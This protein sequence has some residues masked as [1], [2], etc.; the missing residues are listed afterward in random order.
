MVMKTFP[1][2]SNGCGKDQM[3][4]KML[5]IENFEYNLFKNII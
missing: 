2:Y 1:I 5:S 4:V 3:A